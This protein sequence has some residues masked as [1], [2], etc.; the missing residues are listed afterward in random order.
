MQDHESGVCP[1]SYTSTRS[2]LEPVYA[3]TFIDIAL[4]IK[5]EK[6]PKGLDTKKKEA[7]IAG[8][9]SLLKKLQ[10]FRLST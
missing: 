8:D 5:R 1:N 10:G 9:L 3:E 2:P 4:A 7:L 6:Q